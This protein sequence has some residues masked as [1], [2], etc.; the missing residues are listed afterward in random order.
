MERQIMAHVREHS[1]LERRARRMPRA[2]IVLAIIAGACGVASRADAAVKKVA[3]PEVKVDLNDAYRPDAAFDAMVTRFAAAVA[4]KDG[5]ALFALVGPM[6]VWTQAGALVDELDLGREPLHNF[7]VVFGFRAAGA[8]AD[9]GVEN[10]PFWDAL[11]AI[12]QDKTYYKATD[13][14]NLICGPI[15]ASVMD[16]GVFERA[17]NKIE[18]G[19]EPA[20][21]YFT[22]ADTAVAK[23][24]G[25]RGPP[26][27]KVGKVALPVLSVSP[28]GKEGEPAP[29][30]AF[31]EVL[32]PSGKTGWIAASAARPLD[33]ER[34]C[35]AKTAAGDWKIVGY[36]QPE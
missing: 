30:P 15:G 11:S 9:G 29:A 22:L 10:G 17:R 23:A 19:D 2:A 35:Y 31:L 36:D 32:L 5:P 1:R 24:P 25:D 28:V 16:E 13:S 27:A 12:A 3:Y 33:S 7:K 4:A 14:G 18:T 6:F 26:V 8:S 21:W 20:D 34:L